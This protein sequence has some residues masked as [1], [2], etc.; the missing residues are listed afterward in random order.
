MLK[1]FGMVHRVTSL[2]HRRGGTLYII[3]HDDYVTDDITVDPP[4]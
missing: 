1:S 4:V 2:T 3:T